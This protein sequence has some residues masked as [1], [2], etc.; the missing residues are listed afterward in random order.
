MFTA[1]RGER[2]KRNTS[3]SMQNYG[4]TKTDE[5]TMHLRV[6]FSVSMKLATPVLTSR[7][8]SS[9]CFDVKALSTSNPPALPLCMGSK[10]WWDHGK[11]F[12][13]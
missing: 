3:T 13:R 10:K 4:V 8:K 11:Y 2:A 7:G 6:R 9:S 5:M 1:V 12:R